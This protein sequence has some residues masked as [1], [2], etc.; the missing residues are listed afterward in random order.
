MKKN[1]I[2]RISAI[3]LLFT[4]FVCCNAQSQ[5]TE[6]AATGK[7]PG[8]GADPDRPVEGGGKFPDGWSVRTDLNKRTGAEPDASQVVFEIKGDG[9]RTSLGPASTFYNSS[10]MNRAS[11]FVFAARLT[12]QKKP[13]HPIAYG[14]YFGGKDLEKPEQS[15][16]YFMVRNTGEYLI[17]TRKGTETPVITNWTA[18]DAVVKEDESGKQANTLSVQVKGNDVIFSINGKE[19]ERKTKS[20]LPT[21]GL[22]GF[23]IDHNLDVDI[24]KIMR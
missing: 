17:K 8:M 23:R 1:F 16:S 20:D 10:W 3:A 15:Y 2:S 18:N 11:D 9:F 13:T 21:D 5:Q 19:V 12:Q 7:R 4:L 24:D 14:I 22:Y 6:P